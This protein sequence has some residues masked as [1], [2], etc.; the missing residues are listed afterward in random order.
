[1]MMSWLLSRKNR[2]GG[3][4]KALFAIYRPSLESVNASWAAVKIA[5]SHVPGV[6]CTSVPYAG[7]DGAKLRAWDRPEAGIP[8][9][10]FPRN[11][12]LPIVKRSRVWWRPHWL[13]ATF[14]SRWKRVGCVVQENAKI[15]AGGQV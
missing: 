1:M 2:A 15:C 11:T 6:I 7:K 10:G 9:N 14:P 3:Y 13:F 8:H 5:F 4:W 12:P